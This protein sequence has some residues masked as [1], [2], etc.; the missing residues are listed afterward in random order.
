[1]EKISFVIPC[2]H[3]ELTVKGVIDEI[4]IKMT[5]RSDLDYEIIA[6]NDCSPDNVFSVLKELAEKD[7]RIKIVNL[8]KNVGKP[9]AAM[10]GYGVSSG[11]IIINLD[12]DG[13]CPLDKL[14]ELIEPLKN[15]YDVSFAA[16]PSK[17]QSAFKNVG[18][19]V[20]AFMSTLVIGK[21]KSLEFSNFS[22]LK[23]FVINEI[24][25]YDKPY[26]YIGGLIL[27]TTLKI[28]N[29]E[30]EER[31]RTAGV[32]H[33][34]FIKSLKLWLN[35]FTAFS[36]KPLRISTILGALCALIGFVFGV[37]TIINKLIH[38]EMQAGYSSTMAVVL[39]IGGM[40]MM[41]LGMIGEYIGRIYICI[42]SSPQY[43][44][45]ET[46]NLS[47]KSKLEEEYVEKV[48][49]NRSR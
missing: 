4:K 5:E 21:P 7:T 37:I 12:D 14:W 41:M 34:T 16:Y 1:M 35:G 31:E 15:G 30:M 44:I 26:P 24:I 46:I 2:Y 42:N 48:S 13:Q 22:A 49:C 17:K 39:F 25:K 38:P 47:D 18:S 29:V 40:I 23:R 6:V 27:R 3:S 32:G 43:V 9:G 28:S 11:D 10:A 45:K 8:A 19:K 36:V 33:Y 20:N